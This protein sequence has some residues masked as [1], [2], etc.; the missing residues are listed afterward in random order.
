M[1]A[2]HRWPHFN[3]NSLTNK[4]PVTSLIKSVAIRNFKGFSD[5]VRI[6]LR[7]ITLLFGANSAGKSSV[8]HAL[9]Y[10]REILERNNTNADRTLN[11]GDSIDLGGFLNVLHGRAGPAETVSDRKIEI[12]VEMAL[13]DASVP[14]LMP[15]AFEDWQTNDG[16][17]WSF[18]E[19]LQTI[20]RNVNT[21]SL[22]LIIGWNSMRE[23]PVVVGYE[24]GTNSDWCVKVE[25]SSDGRDTRMRINR[26]NSIFMVE[27]ADGDA[28]LAELDDWINLRDLGDT[29][30]MELH[31][32]EPSSSFGGKPP[33]KK[34]SVL[35]E[36]FLA[37]QDA[38]MERP[39][40][41]LRS[42]LNGFNGALPRLDQ[43]LF[44]PAPG[45]KGAANVYI[46]REFTAFLS[47]LT[48]G[49]A[50]L[51]RDQLRKLR[52]IGP[53]RR[54]PPR[55]F[56]VSLTKSD[57]AW[58][59]GMAGWEALLSG[60]QS[61][62]DS[63][64][65]WMNGEDKLNT[66]YAVA[67]KRVQEFEL[68]GPQI[69]AH[70]RVRS[71]LAL[72]DATDLAHQPQDVGVGISQVLPVVVAAQDGNASIVCIEQP[73]LHI[74]P[75]VQVGLGDLFIDGAQDKGLSFLIE[76]HSE[77]L[78]MRLQ[79]RIRETSAG[80]LPP[81]HAPLS[82]AEVNIIYLDRDDAGTVRA[83]EVGLD[84]N[85]KFTDRWPRGFFPERMREALPKEIRE[86]LAAA[87]GKAT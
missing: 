14:E 38:G 36:V 16:E 13:G 43:M 84:A 37:V 28:L 34:V 12:E 51:L 61:L 69:N 70:G 17:V 54:I 35:H 73:E 85:G 8:L 44:I 66:G 2:I 3:P 76:T 46:A 65:E 5:E 62:V 77:H 52:Y 71:R 87:E 82:A 21:V 42:W 86:R 55:G 50:L 59:D 18:Y 74:H 15:D 63:C 20:R 68:N 53:L 29:S 22:R 24:I 56:D 49:P 1:H 45:A 41:G 19:T 4:I 26:E 10:V 58:S 30:A 7:P 6:E 48:I 39:G 9:Q 67:R 25:A 81:E 33:P 32:A 47:W 78:V 57:A 72:I 11:G 83:V 64:S 31:V 40:D 23:E 60:P 79:R 27:A 75:S 80:D